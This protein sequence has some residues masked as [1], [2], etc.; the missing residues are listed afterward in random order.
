MPHILEKKSI[1]LTS[2]LCT[3][4]CAQDAYALFP[5]DDEMKS[6]GARA[7]KFQKAPA[8]WF[9]QRAGVFD[10]VIVNHQ[11]ESKHYDRRLGL[12]FGAGFE[13]PLSPNFSFRLDLRG[14]AVKRRVSDLGVP[15]T[16]S[17]ESYLNL[18]PIASATYVTPAGL[19][20]Y[21]G[22]LWTILPGYKRTTRFGSDDAKVNYASTQF[23]TPHVGVTRRGGIGA[24]GLFYQFGKEQKR[25]VTKTTSDGSS[26]D[27][28]ETKQEPTMLGLYGQF[29]AANAQWVL[30][31]AA[32]SEGEGGERTESGDTLRDDHLEIAITGVWQSSIKAGLGYQTARYSKS[33]YMDL[34]SV[35]FVTG[36]LLWISEGQGLNMQLGCV[37]A[38][39]RDKQ[40]IPEMNARYEVNAFSVVGGISRGI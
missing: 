14:E 34:D 4:L 35:P 28:S 11:T 21:A 15:E 27:M 25:S 26:L 37:G 18:R 3:I 5:G 38:V 13:N 23:L 9:D 32:V 8:L 6:P 22:A 7:L 12:G 24:V 31:G 36:K 16:V 17:D 30:E 29:N 33:A 40:S 19:E 10:G 1:L 20:I 2:L 39:G